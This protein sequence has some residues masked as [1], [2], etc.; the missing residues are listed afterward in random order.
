MP[1]FF[2]FFTTDEM[3]FGKKLKNKDSYESRWLETYNKD[4]KNDRSVGKERKERMKGEKK[5]PMQTWLGR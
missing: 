5:N 2:F 3:T 4:E 1:F